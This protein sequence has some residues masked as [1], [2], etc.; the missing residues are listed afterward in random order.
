MKIFFKYLIV[1]CLLMS[2][3]CS[4]ID[5][6]DTRNITGTYLWKYPTVFAGTLNEDNRIIIQ[7]VNNKFEG[8]YYGTTDEFDKAR[9]GYLPGYCV[10]NM[11]D[12][13][14][15]GDTIRFI[16]SPKINDFFNEYIDISIKSSQDAVKKGYTHWSNFDHFPFK[17]SKNY[18][19]LFIDS[20]TIFFE[21]DSYN[22]MS[23]KKF[24]KEVQYNPS[25]KPLYISFGSNKL[26]SNNC[27]N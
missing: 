24:I 7:K 5:K 19:G 1:L 21:E 8:L 17:T 20:L 13:H 12:L 4:N 10:L 26:Y 27:S 14:I 15:D 3:Q 6:Q 22:G 2:Y 9:E 16:L 11:E 18:Q 25:A 23:E